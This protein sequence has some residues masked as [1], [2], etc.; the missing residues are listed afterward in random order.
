M[1]TRPKGAYPTCCH[2]VLLYGAS[3]GMSAV[4][5]L[6]HQPVQC[7]R[8]TVQELLSCIFSVK[9]YGLMLLHN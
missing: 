4:L 8:K 7:A 6:S 5:L 3:T 1:G 2:I 9:G